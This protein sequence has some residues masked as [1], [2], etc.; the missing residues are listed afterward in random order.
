MTRGLQAKG[1]FILQIGVTFCPNY[2]RAMCVGC[3]RGRGVEGAGRRTLENGPSSPGA[4]WVGHIRRPI[5]RGSHSPFR[6][7]LCPPLAVLRAG[8]APPA[9]GL[10]EGSAGGSRL[11]PSPMCAVRPTDTMAYYWAHIT[12]VA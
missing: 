2:L 8:D 9:P 4:S 3:E 10:T 1:G 11:C 6:D 5:S 7:P 12:T